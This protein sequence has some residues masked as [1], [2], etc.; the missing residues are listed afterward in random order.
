MIFQLFLHLAFL[1]TNAVE[2]VRSGQP[3]YEQCDV[4]IVLHVSLGIFS[5]FNFVALMSIE[6]KPSLFQNRDI[7]PKKAVMVTAF[8]A[9]FLSFIDSTLLFASCFTEKVHMTFHFASL[10]INILPAGVVL[11][12]ML[13]M[14]TQESATRKQH[15]TETSFTIWNACSPPKD[16]VFIIAMLLC[17]I[18]MILVVI[19]SPSFHEEFQ[20]AE[21][22]TSIVYRLCESFATGIVIPLAL[23]QLLTC[24]CSKRTPMDRQAII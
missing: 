13:D 22:T 12:I 10:I 23:K 5:L 7:S 21:H 2:A 14:C 4:F 8:T 15:S 3:R 24:H 1:G 19:S 18:V 6:Y 11:F 17:G 20:Q 9:G 16:I